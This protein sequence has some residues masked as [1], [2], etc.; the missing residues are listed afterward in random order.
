MTQLPMYTEVLVTMATV[1]NLR[2]G[3]GTLYSNHEITYTR[4]Y[5]LP[6]SDAFRICSNHLTHM[7]THI[8]FKIG[9]I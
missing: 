5:V 2:C 3:G 9:F 6:V 8:L 1:L 7:Y 4:E